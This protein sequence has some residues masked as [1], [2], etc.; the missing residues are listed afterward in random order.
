MIRTE[1]ATLEGNK[2]ESVSQLCFKNNLMRIP[3]IIDKIK[4]DYD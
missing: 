2:W 1:F 4:L 3:F